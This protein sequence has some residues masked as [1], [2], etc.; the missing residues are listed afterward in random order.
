MSEQLGG[1]A[2]VNRLKAQVPQWGEKLPELPS[3]IFDVLHQAKHGALEFKGQREGLAQIQQEI[4][5]ANQRT[6]FA[7]I[8]SALLISAALL[9]GL[10]GYAPARMAYG[11]PVESWALGLLGAALLLGNW[12]NG[13][14]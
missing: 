3:L 8:G 1:R 5:R 11:L 13:R 6:F 7:I 2:F 12:P 10:D 14:D 4:R 9:M